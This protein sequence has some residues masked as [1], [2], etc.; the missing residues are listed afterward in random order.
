MPVNNFACRMQNDEG[1]A[2]NFK[3]ASAAPGTPGAAQS[4][5]TVSTRLRS[6]GSA[7]FGYSSPRSF[8]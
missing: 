7:G 6:T 8:L 5:A 1:A 3:T 4:F 2:A